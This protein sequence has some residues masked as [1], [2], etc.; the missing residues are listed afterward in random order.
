MERD[1]SNDRIDC[2]VQMYILQFTVADANIKSMLFD[3]A[4]VDYK[5]GLQINKGFLVKVGIRKDVMEVY[6]EFDKVYEASVNGKVQDEEK[7]QG[8]R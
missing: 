6:E 5:T 1:S 2:Q 7:T 3:L 8:G 4:S